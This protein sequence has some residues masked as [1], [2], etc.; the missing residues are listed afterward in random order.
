VSYSKSQIKWLTFLN[1]S[2]QHAENGGEYCIPETKYKAD[3]YC[4]ENNTIYEFHG[5]FWHGNPTIYDKNEMNMIVKK[6][7]GELYQRTLE[8][9]KIIQNLGYNL[10]TMWENDWKKINNSIKILQKKIKIKYSH[11]KYLK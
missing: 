9:E 2:I 4:K 5:D 3:G 10:V 8:K 6:T 1:Q 11:Y 7:F